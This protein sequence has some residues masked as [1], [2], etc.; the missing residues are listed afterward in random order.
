MRRTFSLVSIV[1]ACW[2]ALAGGLSRGQDAT[3]TPGV[4][5][6]LSPQMESLRAELRHCLAAYYGRPENVQNRNPWEVMHA[7][8]AYG[9]DTEV[10]ANDRR[11]NAIGW[12]CFNGACRGQTLFQTNGELLLPRKGVGVQ[13]HDGQFLGMLAQSKVKSDYPIKVDGRDFTV[14]DLIA[15]E[16]RTCRPRT[17][18]TFKLIG[19]SHYLESDAVWKDDLGQTW[20]IPRLIREELAQP[21]VGAAC[22]GTHRLMGLAYAV[23]KRER[24]GKPIEGEWLRARTFLNDYHAYTLKLQNDD[25]SFSTNWFASRGSAPS[26]ARRVQTSGHILE[27]LAYSVPVEQLD[28]EPIVRAVDYLTGLLLQNHQGDWE[29]GPRGHALHALVIYDERM[30]GASPGSRTANIARK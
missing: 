6:K 1:A 27:W 9:I 20:S 8:I 25:G 22:G 23:R 10:V 13:G 29:I 3:E 4:E 19:L 16:Q 14:A 5:T 24:E 18:L 28:D 12:L 15:Y 26:A 17:E 21:I 2:L 11:V 7:L 30:F